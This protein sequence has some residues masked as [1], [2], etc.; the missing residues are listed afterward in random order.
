M[1]LITKFFLIYA[2]YYISYI[3]LSTCLYIYEINKYHPK[4]L[5]KRLSFSRNF[6]FDYY[7]LI[8]RG[9]IRQIT[10]LFSIWCNKNKYKL[11]STLNSTVHFI[12]P[13]TYRIFGIKF[14]DYS[15]KII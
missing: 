14:S 6:I 4:F 2:I 13:H 10:K 5:R 11:S 7:K 9:K 1:C 15:Q 12:V 8:F 3:L